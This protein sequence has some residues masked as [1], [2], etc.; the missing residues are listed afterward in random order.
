MVHVDL[1]QFTTTTA[2][3]VELG[4]PGGLVAV[5]TALAGGPPHRSQRAPDMRV[6]LFDG[7]RPLAVSSKAH[8]LALPPPRHA[9]EPAAPYTTARA[10][11]R[12]SSRG[13]RVSTRKASIS[14]A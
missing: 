2:G 4:A 12:T 11:I 13:S 3:L 8:H 6:V 9:L 10:P 7:A 1:V 14:F 5:G